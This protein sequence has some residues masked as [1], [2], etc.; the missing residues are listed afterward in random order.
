MFH[1]NGYILFN[2]TEDPQMV[3]T[4]RQISGGE[5]HKVTLEL[6]TQRLLKTFHC[7]PDTLPYT[8][9][10]EQDLRMDNFVSRG[11]TKFEVRDGVVHIRQEELSK[12]N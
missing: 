10:P 9:L 6:L 5:N 8:F 4:L 7:T 2:L 12:Y 3:R 11:F 1:E